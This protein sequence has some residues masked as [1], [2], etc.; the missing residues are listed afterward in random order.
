MPEHVLGIGIYQLPQCVVV[1][2]DFCQNTLWQM[3]KCILAF[4]ASATMHSEPSLVSERIVAFNTPSTKLSGTQLL[5]QC[6]VYGFQAALG[7][8]LKNGTTR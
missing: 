4:I 8:L 6:I 2:F 3:P 1:I 5:P 7:K